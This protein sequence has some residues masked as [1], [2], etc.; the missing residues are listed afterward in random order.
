MEPAVRRETNRALG[1][2]RQ[3][4][5]MTWDR[6]HVVLEFL[7]SLAHQKA[8]GWIPSVAPGHADAVVAALKRQHLTVDHLIN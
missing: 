4:V 2:L 1:G 5:G 7:N 6:W 3:R 8:L